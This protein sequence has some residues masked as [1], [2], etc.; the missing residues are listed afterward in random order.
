MTLPDGFHFS[1][2]SLHDYQTCARRFELRYIQQR[3]WPAVESEPVREYE[4]HMQRGTDFHQLVQRHALGIPAETLAAGIRDDDLRRWWQAY[5]ASGYAA[6]DESRLPGPRWPEVTLTAPLAGYRLLAQYDLLAVE[7]GGPAVIVDWKTNTRKPSRE[8]LAEHPQ[9]RVYRYL[10]VEAGAHLNGGQ[11][12][13]PE[14]V[15]MVYWFAAAPDK[16]EAFSYDAGQHKATGD[17]LA[18]LITEIAERTDFDLVADVAPCRF[19][20]YRSLCERGESA[21]DFRVDD[22]AAIDRHDESPLRLDFDLDQVAE[23]EF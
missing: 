3:R 23:V 7:P 17:E 16:V 12:I 15:N 9:T 21:A 13:E 18:S 4:Q 2:S 1:Q 8:W 14:Q 10:L 11:P 20:T 22:G 5:L 6:G 19:C